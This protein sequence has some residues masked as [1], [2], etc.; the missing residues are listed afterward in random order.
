MTS[1]FVHKVSKVWDSISIDEKLREV[2]LELEVHKK[3]MNIFQVGDSYY[4][5]FNVKELKFDFISEEFEQILGYPSKE[6]SV[7]FFIEKIHPE[8][9]PWFLNIERKVSEFLDKLRIDQ[10]P[11]Y[12]IRFDYRI[13][14]SN[15]DYIRILQQVVTIQHSETGGI[16]K[17]FG[18]HTDISHLKMTGDPVLSF[19]GLNGEPSFI[20]V[21][22]ENMYKLHSGFLSKREAEILSFLVAGK[23]TKEIAKA[24]FISEATVS[25]HRKNLLLKTKAKNTS[26]MIML[27]ITKGWI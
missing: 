1:N 13:Q 16:L 19:I 11:N 7:P 12:K 22:M 5:V 4:Y 26:E 6:L 25:T 21:E 27:A 14:K 10:M 2:Q 3:L 9:Q 20:N 24:L 17:T 23:K 8:D 15:G 18:A